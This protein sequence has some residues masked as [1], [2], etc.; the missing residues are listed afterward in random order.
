MNKAGGGRI[1]GCQ[2]KELDPWKELN[3]D[4]E[5]LSAT[6]ENLSKSTKTLPKVVF[7]EDDMGKTYH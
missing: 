2:W 3:A 4:P 6:Q 1:A 5:P 7:T